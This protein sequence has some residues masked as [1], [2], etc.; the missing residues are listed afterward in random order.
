MNHKTVT[1]KASELVEDFALY[2]RNCV[3]DG[4]VYDLAESIRSGAALPPLVA[5]AKSKRLTD[6]FHRRRAMIR[7]HGDDAECEVMLVDF[8]SDADMVC[9]SITRNAVHGRRLTTADIA[10]C[11]SLGKKY[12]ISRERLAGLLHVTREKLTEITATRFAKGAD[13]EQ[14]VLRRPMNHLA[15]RKLTKAQQEISEHVGGQPALHHVNILLKLI[16]SRS[17][18]DDDR[19]VNGLRELHE[20]LSGL[21]VA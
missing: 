6:G 7:V 11:A 17:L 14:V 3:F 21:L 20:E 16:R 18:P 4:H 10:R 13:G 15:G 19:L 9:D 12:R 5:C 2:P 1:M 8:A